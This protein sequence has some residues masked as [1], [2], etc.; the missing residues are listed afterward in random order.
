MEWH[1]LLLDVIRNGL[2]LGLGLASTVTPFAHPIVTAVLLL[3]FLATSRSGLVV[4]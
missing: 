4:W 1:S 3:G 2:G